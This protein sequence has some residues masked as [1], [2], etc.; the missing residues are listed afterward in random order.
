MILTTPTVHLQ[1]HQNS[2]VAM[3][4]AAQQLAALRGKFQRNPFLHALWLAPLIVTIFYFIGEG[5]KA[6]ERNH[7]A[8]VARQNVE[9]AAA[10]ERKEQ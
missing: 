7:D 2:L 8:W 5:M 6:V 9:N 1:G 3:E 10:V 4:Q